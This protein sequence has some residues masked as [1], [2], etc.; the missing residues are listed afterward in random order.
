VSNLRVLYHKD[1]AWVLK[2]EYNKAM[3]NR[4]DM[5]KLINERTLCLDIEQRNNKKLKK[6]LD[7]A[8]YYIQGDSTYESVK[9]RIDEILNGGENA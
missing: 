8:L 7:L 9:A 1:K 6:A 4:R 2:K 5:A 3:R